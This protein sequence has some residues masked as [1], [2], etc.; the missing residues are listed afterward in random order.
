MPPQEEGLD[1]LQHT[2]Y[3]N[4]YATLNKYPYY[5]QKVENVCVSKTRVHCLWKKAGIFY[6]FL[7]KIGK[8]WLITVDLLH[9]RVKIN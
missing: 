8:D 2:F 7:H 3:T 9:K 1:I 4:S 5:G 6:Y